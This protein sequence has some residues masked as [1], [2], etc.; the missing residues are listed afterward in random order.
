MC[1]YNEFKPLRE[2]LSPDNLHY[3]R[4]RLFKTSET[5]T[6]FCKVNDSKFL[7]EALEECYALKYDEQPLYGKI[8]FIL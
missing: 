2:F 6:E 1:L 3:D 5:A 4:F 8:K 7:M